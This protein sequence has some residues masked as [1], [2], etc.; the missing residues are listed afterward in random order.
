MRI[1]SGYLAE[2]FGSDA[3]S[4]AVAIGQKVRLA[5][6]Y[7][8]FRLTS[9]SGRRLLITGD[10]VQDGD[11]VYRFLGGPQR[12][13]LGAENF[14]DPARW[15][16]LGGDAGAVY[17]YLGAAG[18][19]NLSAQDYADTTRWKLLG[20][21]EGAAYQYMG[22]DMTAPQDLATHRLP[23]PALLEAGSRS[24]ASC[25]R[26]INV[27]TSDSNAIGGLVVYNDVRASTQA[28]VRESAVVAAALTVHAAETALLRATSDA[29][30]NSSGG[31]SIDGQGDSLAV[32]AL[33]A[34]NVVLATA[35][36][37]IADSDVTTTGDVRVAAENIAQIDATTLATSLSAGQAIGVTLAFNSIGWNAQNFLFNAIDTLLGDPLIANAFGAQQAAQANA[38]IHDSTVHAGGAVDVHALD[39]A[40]INAE[41][42]NQSTANVVAITGSESLAVGV[43]FASNMVN[44]QANAGI[45]YAVTT[46]YTLATLPALLNTGDRVV[47]RPRQG[48]RVHRRLAARASGRR[49]DV[50]HRPGLPPRL[51]GHRG[52]RA[53]RERRGQ[54]ADPRQRRGRL[55]RDLQEHRRPRPDRRLPHPRA[56]RLPVHDVLR[57]AGDPAG[58]ARARSRPPARSI[59]SPAPSGTVREPRR[60]PPRTR[61]SRRSS[62]A[63]RSPP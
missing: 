53:E 6:D 15:A 23:R 20:G 42:S 11:D 45:D 13:D 46:E 48:L 63:T 21:V 2:D 3:G 30:V 62:S 17:Q 29:T 41:V 26:G 54:L 44:A 61:R 7:G 8:A 16:K 19:L 58:R 4:V 52:R 37:E 24:P 32:N 36:A 34:T 60:P 47:R 35:L 12:V 10:N 59:A 55:D 57:H 27:T 14:A 18:T 38:Y 5:D 49:R 9:E 28:Y 33:I 39:D 50:R 31:S 56:H 1:A 25:P 22:T 43:V 51:R 40:L